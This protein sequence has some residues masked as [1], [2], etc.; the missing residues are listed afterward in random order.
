MQ[1]IGKSK[2]H[3]C[4]K[5]D[6]FFRTIADEGGPDRN[7]ILKDLRTEKDAVP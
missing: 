6:S 5:Y 7:S 3:F 1:F 4:T 2:M